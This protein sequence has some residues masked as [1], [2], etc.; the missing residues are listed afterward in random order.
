[1]EL[2]LETFRVK[3]MAKGWDEFVVGPRG[4]VGHDNI[5]RGGIFDAKS[6][7]RW[8]SANFKI[9]KAEAASLLEVMEKPNL[10]QTSGIELGGTKYYLLRVEKDKRLMHLRT[11]NREPMTVLFANVLATQIACVAV[12]EPGL[13][14]S[15]ICADR[16]HR[17]ANYLLC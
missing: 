16:Q 12:G 5:V 14:S 10:A 17:V 3:G 2:F 6:G 7:K 4:F 15:L 8:S 13:Q 11:K 9:S 1:M